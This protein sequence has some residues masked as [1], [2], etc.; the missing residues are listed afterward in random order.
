MTLSEGVNVT[1]TGLDANSVCLQNRLINLTTN[2]AVYV[3]Q[4]TIVTGDVIARVVT[5]SGTSI[6]AIG[7]PTT[8]LPAN[9]AYWRVARVGASGFVVVSRDAV[10]NP[11]AITGVACTVSGTTITAGSET[12]IEGTAGTVNTFGDFDVG[13]VDNNKCICV[14]K[15][16][17]NTNDGTARAF[18]ISGTSISSVGSAHVFAPTAAYLWVDGFHLDGTNCIVSYTDGSND[19]NAQVLQVSGTTVTSRTAIILASTDTYIETMCVGMSSTVAFVCY[20]QTTGLV[21]TGKLHHITRSGTT[22][23][24]QGSQGYGSLTNPDILNGIT[25]MSDTV[26]LII[27][28]DGDEQ[29]REMYLNSGVLTI[30]DTLTVETPNLGTNMGIAIVDTSGNSAAIHSEDDIAIITTDLVATATVGELTASTMTKPCAINADGD[31]V[32]IGGINSLGFPTLLKFPT[33]LNADATVVFDPEAGDNIGV[34]CGVFDADA[35][36]IAGDFG[37][38]TVQKSEDA[39]SSFANKDA[40]TVGAVEAFIVGP[41]S[42]D[43]VLVSD[44]DNDDIYETIDSG[45]S[46]TQINAS[47]GIVANVVERLDKNVQE[48]VFGNDGNATDNIDYTVNSGIDLE[49]YTSGFDQDRDITGLEIG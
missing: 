18:N 10:T 34:Q 14:Y 39:G 4:D 37:S 36:W 33:A 21:D 49:D 17:N 1:A 2:K 48:S 12:N 22:L 42:D 8:I 25:R 6:S 20:E 16:L 35:I 46:W 29:I 11:G 9:G 43:R 15:D 28:N 19:V 23:T 27:Y 26:C 30:G 40:S 31:Y 32:Y 47:S 5:T 24:N 13:Q 38:T 3:Y 7:S 41:D 44:L 45:T